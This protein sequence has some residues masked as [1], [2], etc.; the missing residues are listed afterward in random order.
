VVNDVDHINTKALQSK[1]PLFS[2][3][4]HASEIKL[5]A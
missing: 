2:A 5:G 4:G 3:R 1:R